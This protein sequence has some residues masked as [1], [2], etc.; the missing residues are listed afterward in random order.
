MSDMPAPPNK[1]SSKHR[2]IIAVVVLIGVFAVGMAAG[3]G[4]P[5]VVTQTKVETKTVTVAVTPTECVDAVHQTA[6]I[7]KAAMLYRQ[8]ATLIARGALTLNSGMVHLAKAKMLRAD[9]LVKELGSLVANG[10]SC[11]AQAE[12]S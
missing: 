9:D 2:K 4:S 3:G 1:L 5:E 7:A 11:L 12:S 6:T 10:K 8:A